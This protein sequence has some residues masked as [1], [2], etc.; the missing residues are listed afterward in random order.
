MRYLR[1]L[2]ILA[3]F[4]SWNGKVR[5][6][7][8]SKKLG[9][10][11]KA[12]VE[13]KG[14]WFYHGC[15]YNLQSLNASNPRPTLSQFLSFKIRLTAFPKFI[16]FADLLFARLFN[17]ERVGRVDAQSNG[18]TPLRTV[19]RSVTRDGEPCYIRQGGNQPSI[20]YYSIEI[21]YF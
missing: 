10:L 8:I 15:L 17:C 20:V 1:K 14:K 11:D 7:Y 9:A 13:T 16:K 3:F 19:S 21:K 5:Q 12:L 6:R 4:F 18:T 2:K